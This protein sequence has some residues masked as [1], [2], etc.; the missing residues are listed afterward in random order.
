MNRYVRMI[1]GW[2][3]PLLEDPV[4]YSTPN[5]DLAI[6]VA[7]E[8]VAVPRAEY[9]S[10]E[11]SHRLPARPRPTFI[12]IPSWNLL[13]TVLT[14]PRERQKCLREARCS[15]RYNR[16]AQKYSSDLLEQRKHISGIGN[17]WINRIQLYRDDETTL[18]RG[19]YSGYRTHRMKVG[20]GRIFF[21]RNA[22]KV[23]IPC[24]V[25]NVFPSGGELLQAGEGTPGHSSDSRLS[26]PYPQGSLQLSRFKSEP[27]IGHEWIF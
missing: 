14:I 26:Y 9:L 22:D 1:F 18:R 19:C 15:I 4:I 17:Q 8:S 16:L 5:G 7:E 12:P 11:S 10:E 25:P 20:L 2:K 13:W 3:N 21:W 24:T 23:C 27:T 6:Q